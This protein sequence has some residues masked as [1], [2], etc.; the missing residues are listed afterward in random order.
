M[1]A[2]WVHQIDSVNVPLSHAPLRKQKIVINCFS[3]PQKK[4]IL[5]P[6]WI[7]LEYIYIYNKHSKKIIMTYMWYTVCSYIYIYIDWCHLG[8]TVEYFHVCIWCWPLRYTLSA[9]GW[10]CM[11]GRLQSGIVVSAITLMSQNWTW[12]FSTGRSNPRTQPPCPVTW[13]KMEN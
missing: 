9:G 3:P 11:E 2:F 1:T 4:Y 8:Y 13:T 5:A 10:A 6:K 12:A 7:I